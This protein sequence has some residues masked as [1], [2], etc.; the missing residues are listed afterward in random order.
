MK[1][2]RCPYDVIDTLEASV[3]P[4]SWRAECHVAVPENEPTKMT[5]S[6]ELIVARSAR[7]NVLMSMLSA[8]DSLNLLLYGVLMLDVAAAMVVTAHSG[9][10]KRAISSSRARVKRLPLLALLERNDKF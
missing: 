5:E 4:L 6:S 2:S 1:P 8:R 9:A 10:I 7:Y 3:L